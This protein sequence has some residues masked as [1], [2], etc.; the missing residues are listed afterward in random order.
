MRRSG[1]PDYPA[2]SSEA[3]SFA[4]YCARLHALGIA[5]PTEDAEIQVVTIKILKERY[6]AEDLPGEPALIDGTLAEATALVERWREERR[7]PPPLPRLWYPHH[8]RPTLPAA[9]RRPRRLRLPNLDTTEQRHPL[10][11]TMRRL[12]LPGLTTRRPPPHPRTAPTRTRLRSNE[13]STLMF[14]VSLD[15]ARSTRARRQR[16]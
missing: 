16:G 10:D 9:R 1:H 14:N 7:D 2:R 12:R 8:Q 5:I 4:N 6:A 13:P 15:R 11:R 3:L